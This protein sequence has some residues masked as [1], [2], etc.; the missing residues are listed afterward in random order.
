[1]NKLEARI[2]KLEEILERQ[3]EMQRRIL[4]QKCLTIGDR[5]TKEAAIKG[6]MQGEIAKQAGI[7]RQS[8]SN[9]MNGY[10]IPRADVLGKIAKVLNVTCDYLIYGEQEGKDNE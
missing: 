9:Y 4:E 7:T 3:K 2:K 8:V 10:K 5:I 6:I 1:M